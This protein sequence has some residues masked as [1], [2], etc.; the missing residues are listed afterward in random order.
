MTA[1]KEGHSGPEEHNLRRVGMSAVPEEQVRLWVGGR[2]VVDVMMD[3]LWI[4]RWDTIVLDRVLLEYIMMDRS[5]L[6]LVIVENI[7]MGI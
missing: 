2:M 3:G 6:G 5:V 1:A 7:M 4:V